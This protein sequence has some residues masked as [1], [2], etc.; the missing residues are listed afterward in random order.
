MFLSSEQ[1]DCLLMCMNLSAG[2]TRASSL[3]K[4]LATKQADCFVLACMTHNV[5]AKHAAAAH[6]AK[7]NKLRWSEFNHVE[8]VWACAVALT[9]ESNAVLGAVM[10]S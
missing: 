7:R 6:G 1:A 9:N 5:C 8:R 10:R 3:S 4:T 2:T